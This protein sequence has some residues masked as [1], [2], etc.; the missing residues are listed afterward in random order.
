MRV[1]YVED[2]KLLA[3]A[4]AYL[5][6]K[7]GFLVDLAND[8]ESGLDFALSNSYDCIVLDIM[9]PKLSGLRILETIRHR[10]INTPVIML[11]ALSQTHDK[12][13]ALD[14]G[15]DDYLAKPF[16]SAELIAR[17]KALTRRP[18]LQTIEEIHFDDLIYLPSEHTLNGLLLTAKEAGIFEPLIRHPEQTYA[19]T[20]LLSHAWGGDIDPED[21]ENYVEVYISNLRQKLRQLNSSATIKTIRNVGYKLTAQ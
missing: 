21:A 12:V 8:G 6:K 17:I 13:H 16:K 15:A 18:P 7:A 4:V 1:L 10:N 19:K 20:W 9:L 2:E 11:S 3:D 14:A 5:L